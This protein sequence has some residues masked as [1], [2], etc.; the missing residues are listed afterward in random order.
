M[1][2]GEKETCFGNWVDKDAQ[3]QD[4]FIDLKK[5][6]NKCNELRCPGL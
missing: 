5:Q 2:K 1:K 6:V 4:K 3:G